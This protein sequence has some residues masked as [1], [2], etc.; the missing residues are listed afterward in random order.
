MPTGQF[1]VTARPLGR[2]LVRISGDL[3]ALELHGPLSA[4]EMNTFFDWSEGVLRSH[5]YALVLTDCADAAS[6]STQSR[7]TAAERLRAHGEHIAAAVYGMSPVMR[8]MLQI[9]N[10]AVRMVTRRSLNIEAF[11]TE[12]DARA[13]LDRWRPHMKAASEQD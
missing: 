4:E 6:G 12:T 2:H 7:K 9:F 5:G 10:G 8:S 3:I 1:A 11:A 13:W